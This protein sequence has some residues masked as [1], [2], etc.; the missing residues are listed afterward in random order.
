[1]IQWCLTDIISVLLNRNYSYS[2]IFFYTFLLRIQYHS[3]ILFYIHDFT[4]LFFYFALNDTI[5][6]T[7]LYST[8]LYCSIL[9]CIAL[10]CIVMYCI[11]LYSGYSPFLYF[12]LL[13]LHSDQHRVV[14]MRLLPLH[15]PFQ[16]PSAML[17]RHPSYCVVHNVHGHYQH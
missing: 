3:A 7:Q 16:M 5:Y 1:M 17:K 6:S 12:L 9:Y 8:L 2:A 13:T 10:C 4:L 11:E 14:A 15:V